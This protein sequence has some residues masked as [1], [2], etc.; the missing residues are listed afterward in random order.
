MPAIVMAFSPIRVGRLRG[1]TTIGA[2]TPL[3]ASGSITGLLR[4]RQRATWKSTVYLGWYR[5][6]ETM[7]DL[8]N[9]QIVPALP[10]PLPMAILVAI[11]LC[12][13]LWARYRAAKKR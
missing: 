11:V 12:L 2:I 6:E 3:Q 9:G 13:S 4:S 10:P 8:L 7:T 5:S 1:L